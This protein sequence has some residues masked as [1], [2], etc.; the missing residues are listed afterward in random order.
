MYSQ[1]NT[2]VI[3]TMPATLTGGELLKNIRLNSV[4]DRVVPPSDLCFLEGGSGVCSVPAY[5]TFSCGAELDGGSGSRVGF[6]LQH[7]AVL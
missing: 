2:G 5:L 3:V 7:N 1:L 6:T 4:E